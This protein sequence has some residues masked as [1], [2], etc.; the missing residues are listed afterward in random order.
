MFDTGKFS[1]LARVSKRT[2]RYYDSIDL[3]KPRR[4]DS[5]TGIRYYSAEQFADLNRIISLKELGLTLDQIRRMLDDDI[6]AEEIYGMLLLKKAEAE[7]LAHLVI[8]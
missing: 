6:S 4:V 2:L 1:R 3:F 7:S 8:R 5:E